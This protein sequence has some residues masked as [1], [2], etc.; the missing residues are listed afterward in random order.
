[1][2]VA[3]IAAAQPHDAEGREIGREPDREGR[4][5]DVEDDR[6]GELQAGQQD[7]I[8]IHH[9]L[10]PDVALVI[11]VASIKSRRAYCVPILR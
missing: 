6:K 5:N 7:R 1:V 2:L 4:E 10:R 9:T 11:I 8:K 3:V